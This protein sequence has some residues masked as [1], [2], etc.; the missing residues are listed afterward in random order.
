M[1][2]GRWR[3][4][5]SSPVVLW[6][7]FVIVHLWLGML[8][9][10][11]PGLPFGD[12]TIVYKF[13]SD[14]FAVA[15]Y[16]VGVDSP[17]VYPVLAIAPMML[18][19]LFG[20]DLYASTWLSM[21]M[22]LDAVAFA[23]LLGGGR[24]SRSVAAWWWLVFLLLLGPI[25]L[26][27]IDSV[28]VPIAIVGVLLLV[29]RPQVASLLLA[30]AT[31][32][33][34]W[35]A[36]ILVAAVIALRSRMRLLGVAL[37]TSLAVIALAL[38]FGAG[39]NVLSFVTQQ[40]GRGLQVES[41]VSTIWLW[42]A[43][44][45]L[46]G[47]TVYYDQGILTWQLRGAGVD[48]AAAVMTPVL[49]VALL[50]V[51]VLGLLAMRRAA[52]VRQLLPVLVL[53]FVTAFIAFNKVGSPQ[54]VSWFAVAV[55]LGLAMQG[56]RFTVP[57]VLVAAIAALTQLIYPFFY[58]RLLGLDPVLLVVITTRNLL[59][60]VLL[61]WAAARLVVLAR[62]RVPVREPGD[63]LGDGA[64]RVSAVWPFG[65]DGARLEP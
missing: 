5:A 44:A 54:Y 22:A 10:Y 35:P 8:N 46:G 16:W 58:D 32:I 27:R 7:L 43:L 50:A 60:F 39:P 29:R 64:D 34:V 30:V 14:Q 6:A 12:V 15:H 17:W 28:T 51:T 21:I 41:P 37:S 49:L 23:F 11:G 4:I 26:G 18:A 42:R 55:V 57:A 61:G 31:W 20:P 24:R 45:G 65:H 1:G 36:A 9:L 19:R 53:A 62:R 38:A 47:T 52:P 40:T 56:R 59:F 2:L 33:K 63:E 3:A 13:W 48:A 25:A